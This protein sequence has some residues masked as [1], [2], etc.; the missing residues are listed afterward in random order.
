MRN[1]SDFKDLVA[2]YS[3]QPM[4]GG[5]GNSAA[6]YGQNSESTVVSPVFGFFPLISVRLHNALRV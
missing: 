3:F 4:Q 5:H 6:I 1:P 2:G